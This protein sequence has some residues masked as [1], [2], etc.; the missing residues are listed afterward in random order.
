MAA[1]KKTIRDQ[2]NELPLGLQIGIVSVLGYAGYRLYKRLTVQTYTLPQG[3]AGLP[4]VGYTQGG[5]PQLWNP[6]PLVDELHN[7]MDGLFT[8]SGTKDAAW[9]KLL[10]LP[11]NDMVTA[12]YNRF[13]VKHGAGET[14]TAW[15]RQEN[16]YDVLSGVKDAVLN[17]LATIGL[18]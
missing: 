13:N 10:E 11:S 6:E 2:F 16:Y 7:V 18:N 17:R 9:K 8:L 14:L 5:Q 4:V 3:G 1:K 15:I 12:V